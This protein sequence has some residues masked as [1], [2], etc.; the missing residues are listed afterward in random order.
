VTGGQGESQ[1]GQGACKIGEYGQILIR[2][3]NSIYCMIHFYS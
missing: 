2:G 1:A 3:R